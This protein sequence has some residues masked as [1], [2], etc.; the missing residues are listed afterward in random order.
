MIR[1]IIKNNDKKHKILFDK[2]SEG[3]NE[4]KKPAQILAFIKIFVVIGFYKFIGRP[5]LK[6]L[7]NPKMRMLIITPIITII[8]VTC[9]MKITTYLNEFS[10]RD[11]GRTKYYTSYTVKPGDT[12]WAIA[13]DMY[14]INPEYKSIRG[15]ASDI[16]LINHCGE[17][18]KAGDKIRLP[19][20]STSEEQSQI[21]MKYI[22][23]Y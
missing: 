4:K 7:S 21:I 15:Y 6:L 23:N 2:W 9:T 11:L 14:Q 16:M 20:Y 13:S 5:L 18:I 3:I 8:L 17:N 1:E 10:E 12:V 22:T 19:Y